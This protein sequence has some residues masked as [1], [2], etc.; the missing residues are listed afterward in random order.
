MKND[1]FLQKEQ[2]AH[3]RKT[4]QLFVLG[5]HP[6]DEEICLRILKAL[7]TR[8]RMFIRNVY[9]WSPQKF[10][11]HLADCARDARLPEGYGWVIL[12]FAEGRFGVEKGWLT[13]ASSR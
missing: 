7:E 9:C 13:W 5:K 10:E 2:L 3:I 6:E 4:W 1:T 11:D 12:R 8:E